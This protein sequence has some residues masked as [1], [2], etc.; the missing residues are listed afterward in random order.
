MNVLSRDGLMPAYRATGDASGFN[1]IC[2]RWIARF[3]KERGFQSRYQPWLQANAD[4]AWKNRRASDNLVWSRWPQPTPDGSLHSWACSSAVVLLHVAEV[5]GEVTA[6]VRPEIVIAD[7]EGT[8]FRSWSAMGTAFGE[9][10]ASGTLPNQMR[11]D[12][13]LGGG[14]TSM[15]RPKLSIT[16]RLRLDAARHDH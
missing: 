14:L 13:F 9:S 16:G 4:A 1:G 2:A 3:A 5:T 8:N 6:I 12:G 15:K 7:F 10:P 11:V